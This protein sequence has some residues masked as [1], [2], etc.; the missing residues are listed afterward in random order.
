M[1][2]NILYKNRKQ[3]SALGLIASCLILAIAL[4]GCAHVISKE[5]MKEVDKSISFKDLIN[6]P[7]KYTGKTVLLGGVIVNT[8]NKNDGTVMNIYQTELDSYGEPINTDVS[9]GRFL[10]KDVKFLDSAIFRKGRRVTIAGVVQGSQVLKL[11]NID[12]RYPVVV[13][14]EIDL[15]ETGRSKRGQYYRGF[16][17]PYWGYSWYGSYGWRQ[18]RR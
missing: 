9:Q 10:A 18:W 17:E 1:D 3:F 14:K 13:I 11:G 6:D 15:W 8:V 4:A 2:K 5:T 7:G 16:W 12:Y